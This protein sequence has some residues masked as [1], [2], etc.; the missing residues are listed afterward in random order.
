MA[1]GQ[2]GFVGRVLNLSGPGKRRDDARR[3]VAPP[4]PVV[5]DIA[6]VEVISTIKGDA[7]RLV[8]HRQGCRAAISAEAWTPV[9][10]TV[11]IIRVFMST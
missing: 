6:D 10:A 3:R 2:R 4:Y 9:P 5:Q 11:E 7:V 1:A 8:E